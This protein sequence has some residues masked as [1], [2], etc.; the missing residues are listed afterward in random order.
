M[1]AAPRFTVVGARGFIGSALVELLAGA[2]HEVHGI[3]HD[4]DLGSGRDLGHVIYCSGVAATAAPDADYAFAVHV[5][6]VRRVLEREPASLL[7]LS[8]TR[9]Y[10]STP[11]THENAALTVAPCGSDI[12]R[13]SKIA[14][15]ALCLAGARPGVRVARLSNVA[16]ENFRS[17]LFLND[18][19]RQAA[20]SGRVAV[21]TTR[22][23]AKDY[24]LVTD[25]CRYLYAIATRG[26]ERIYNVADGANVENGAIYD[27][28]TGASG[29]RIEIAPD[30]VR[31]ITPPISTERLRAEFGPPRERLLDA[32]PALYRA[33]A[34]HAAHESR[35]AGAASG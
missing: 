6:G 20:T 1:T 14:G 32:V 2:G 8:T 29:A 5:E 21:R 25:V 30:A 7:Y 12:Y 13:I 33:F 28:V 15:E 16:G 3:R 19:L 22:D 26:S 34:A 17:T 27:A 31:A 35:A 23:S 9:V 11:E 4:D 24:L 18:V 10:G